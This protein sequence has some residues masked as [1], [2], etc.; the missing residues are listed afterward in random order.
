MSKYGATM[1]NATQNRRVQTPGV[2]A[3][4]GN[5]GLTD[6]ERARRAAHYNATAG[7]K[8]L[9]PGEY[10]KIMRAINARRAQA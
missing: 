10:A 6:S 3:P 1:R 8:K 4:R 9:R 7:S 5:D 2:V